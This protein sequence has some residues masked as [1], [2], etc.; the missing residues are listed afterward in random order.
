MSLF[1]MA[2]FFKLFVISYIIFKKN[3]QFTMLKKS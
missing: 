1:K 3:R 2:A